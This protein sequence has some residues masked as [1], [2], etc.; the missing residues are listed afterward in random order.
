VRDVNQYALGAQA[1]A[2]GCEV[3]RGGIADDDPASLEAAVRAAA[4]GH[5]VVVLSGGSSVG[6]RDHTPEVFAGLGEILF[7]GIAVRPGRPTLVARAGAT[8]LVGMPG[9][10]TS[11]IVIFQVFMRPLLRRLGGERG[12]ARWPAAARLA[13]AYSS[14]AGREDYL[15]VRLV[16]RAGETW[17]EILPGGSAVLSNLVAADGL[18]I[19]PAEVTAVAAGAVV[20]VHLL[21]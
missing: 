3:T 9:V 19:V 8:L 13:A 6:G 2:A 4:S 16:Q 20:A 11:A 5:D 17:A 10:P 14:E 1:A 15:R 18:V 7:H 21:A 12:G